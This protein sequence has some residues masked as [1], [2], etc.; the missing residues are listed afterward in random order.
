[1][2]KILILVLIFIS[3][4]EASTKVVKASKNIKYKDLIDAR[5]VYLDNVSESN[6]KRLC[7]HATRKDILNNSY[8]AKKHIKKGKII[9]LKDLYKINSNGQDK[10]LF[11]FGAIQIE[12]NAKLIRETKDYIKIKT[13]NGKLEKIYKNGSGR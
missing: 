4:I 13:E 6:I 11:N 8:Y 9:C 5:V 12:R 1:V 3:L 10:V 2:N 7:K